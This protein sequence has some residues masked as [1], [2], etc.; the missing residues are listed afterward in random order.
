[1]WK[2][3]KKRLS[4]PESVISL[5]LG[6]AV[7]GISAVLLYNIFQTK[8]STKTTIPGTTQEN[9]ISGVT[10]ATGLSVNTK[11]EVPTQLPTK[12]KVK[13]GEDLWNISLKY[14]KSGYNWINIAKANNLVNPDLLQAGQELI[15]PKVEAIYPQGNINGSGVQSIAESSYKVKKDDTLWDISCRAYADCYK[16]VE[17]AKTNQLANPDLI[18]INQEIKLPR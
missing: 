18:E 2:D 4:D 12:H 1:M 14:Y 10:G 16:W 7:V 6:V 15:I 13:N 9:G 8:T 11:P 5:V 17:V 3:I